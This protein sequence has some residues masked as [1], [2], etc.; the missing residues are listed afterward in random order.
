MAAVPRSKHSQ[1]RYLNVIANIFG[2]IWIGF[3]VN[4]MLRPRAAFAIF[5][6]DLPSS[7]ADQKLVESLM[8]IYGARDLFMGL[9]TYFTAW[10]GTRKACGWTLIAGAGVAGVDGLVS[11]QQIGGGQWN[12]WG[13]APM[14]FVVGALLA[15][16]WD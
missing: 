4:A 10:F 2:T 16:V 6:F 12:H 7:A 9:A 13:Y 15:G 5:E 8:I 1:S 11:L 14:I 3:G